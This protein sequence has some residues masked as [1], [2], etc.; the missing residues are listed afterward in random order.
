MTLLSQSMELLRRAR[1]L[2]RELEREGQAPATEAG[3]AA[4]LP[5]T[6]KVLPSAP[7][8]RLAWS[9]ASAAASAHT[10]EGCDNSISAPA[11]SAATKAMALVAPEAPEASIP[12]PL[13]SGAEA[14]LA[15]N[16][17]RVYSL[18]VWRRTHAPRGRTPHAA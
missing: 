9:A 7:R 16:G 10:S 17:A 13:S 15:G 1:A 12:G 14:F 11:T 6:P 8:L 4:Q 3:D 5:A 18:D 2:L